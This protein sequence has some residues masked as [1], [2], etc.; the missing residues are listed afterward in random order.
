MKKKH[1]IWSVLAVLLVVAVIWVIWGNATVGLTT[2]T[3]TE[4]NLPA[5]FDGYRIAHV[6]DLHN[7]RL[8]E[9]TVAKLK[10]AQPDII[11]ITGD[12]VDTHRTDISV[13]LA[14]AAEAVKIAPVYYITGNH[15]VALTGVEFT[16]LTEGL[17]TL[18]VAVLDDTEVYLEKDGAQISVV[19]HSWGPTDGVGELT[20]FAGY[21]I[22]L[23]HSPEPTE[24]DN[25]VAAGYDLVLCG[26]FHGGQFRI[27]FLGGL[28]APSQGLFP[29]NDAGLVSRGDTDMVVSRG[30]GNSS[31]PLRLNN[32]PEVILVILEG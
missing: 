24:F 23:S 29:E 1:I 20:E 9:Q 3:V 8:W 17:R 26:H 10:K 15:E 21:R 19:G 2:Y 7:S 32:R 12:L 16:Q 31:F 28:Y 27:P 6:S 22:L 5:P 30:I 4:N 11:C 13:A 18:G 25:Y 14:F